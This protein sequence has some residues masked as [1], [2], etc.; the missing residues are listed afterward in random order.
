MTPPPAQNKITHTSGWLSPHG[1]FYKCRG[2]EHVKTAIDI[3]FTD[4]ELEEK[5]WMKISEGKVM[6][7]YSH[8]RGKMIRPSKKQID[9][10]WDW[11]VARGKGKQFPKW[12][13]DDSISEDEILREL[14]E[15]Y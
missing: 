7:A 2:W 15:M 10:L 4:T 1:Q 3:G 11:F 14:E 12:I 13:L 6:P 5:G 9:L 8:K